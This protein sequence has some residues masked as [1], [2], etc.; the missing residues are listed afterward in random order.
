MIHFYKVFDVKFT[1]PL[2]D[3]ILNYFLIHSKIMHNC[4]EGPLRPRGGYLV[5]DYICRC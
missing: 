1:I 2:A 5:G 3:S 4:A